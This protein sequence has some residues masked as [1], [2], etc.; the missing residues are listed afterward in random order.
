MK[1]FRLKLLA[2]DKAFYDGGCLSLTVPSPDGKYGILAGH[3]NAVIAVTPGIA[4][5]TTS[6]GQKISAFVASGIVKIE[7]GQA[8][9]LVESCYNAEDA[10]DA[11]AKKA[12]RDAQEDAARRESRFNVLAAE[13]RIARALGNA[14]VTDKQ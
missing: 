13:I 3:C 11:K 8:L 7:H 4:L 2:A 1:S 10:D 12:V 9:M 6:D 5:F 14:D